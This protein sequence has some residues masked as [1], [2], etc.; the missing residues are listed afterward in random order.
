MWAASEAPALLSLIA[1]YSGLLVIPH[2]V[3]DWPLVV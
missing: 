3:A 2:P 1:I